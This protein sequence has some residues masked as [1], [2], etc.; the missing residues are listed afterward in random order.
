MN[1]PVPRNRLLHWG[2]YLAGLCLLLL[3]LSV[4]VVRLG[5]W[6]PGLLMY[7]L[8]SLVGTA[9]LLL[10][11]VM[12]LLPRCAALRPA[13]AK[14]AALVAL[15]AALLVSLLAGRGDVPPIHD[16]STDTLDPPVFVRAQQQRGSDSNSLEIKP[17]S[18]AQQLQAYPGLTSTRS[19]LPREA[20]FELALATAASLGW[21]IYHTDA[22][23]GVFEAV[24]STAIM[25]FKDDVVIRLRS[26]GAGTLLDLRSVSRVGVG[27]LGANAKRIRSFQQAFRDR[28]QSGR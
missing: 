10:F 18:I 5:L 20:A 17:D 4:L 7:A 8:A 16:I 22:T 24:D 23:A 26:D 21:D 25:G 1:E 15:P 12:F 19:V 14:R 6:R 2:G 13:I 27:D 11:I 28:E 3:P 9:L